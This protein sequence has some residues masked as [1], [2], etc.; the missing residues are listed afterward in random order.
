MVTEPFAPPAAVLA[1]FPVDRTTFE[2]WPVFTLSPPGGGSRG[3]IFYLHGGGHATELSPLHWSFLVKLVTATGWSAVVPVFPLAPTATHRDVQPVLKR[4]Y[5]KQPEGRV[6]IVGDSSGGGLALALAQALAKDR[7]PEQ[8]IL[9]SPWLDATMENPE[10]AVLE[11][12]DPFST[13]AGMVRFARQFAG[14]DPLSSPSLSPVRGPL[15]DLGR[16]TV[17]AGSVDILT[18]DARV[19]RDQAGPGT[20]VDLREYPGKTHM[21]MLLS[22]PDGAA[23]V[24]EIHRALA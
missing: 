17:F 8:L 6:A 14:A 13:K 5:E 23:I 1:G 21:W 7:R 24:E 19:L 9:L 10:I 2:S 4:L 3:T 20:T 11:P 12:V 16:I 18:P 22:E 15:E